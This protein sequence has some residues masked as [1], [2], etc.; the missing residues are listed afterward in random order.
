MSNLLRYSHSFNNVFWIKD[1]GLIVNEDVLLSPNSTMKAD[2]VIKTGTGSYFTQ[3]LENNLLE[4]TTYTLSLYIWATPTNSPT[5]KLFYDLNDGS[6]RVQTNDIGNYHAT[7][8]WRR[9]TF[10]FTTPATITSVDHRAGFQ[11][12][13]SAH[14]TNEYFF[15]GIQLVEGSEPVD[16][17]EEIEKLNIGYIPGD[18]IFTIHPDPY[19]EFA[20]PIINGSDQLYIKDYNLIK[21]PNFFNYEY[22]NFNHI[23]L[24]EIDVS[25]SPDDLT[26][27][28]FDIDLLEAKTSVANYIYQ[29]INSYVFRPNSTY[30]FSYYIRRISGG[31]GSS[32]IRLWSSGSGQIADSYKTVR[33]YWEL[34]SWTFT[35]PE[36]FTGDQLECGI[37]VT[38]S[39]DNMLIEIAD[40]QLIESDQRQEFIRILP[41][42]ENLV[43]KPNSIFCDEVQ[44]FN[45]GPL[46]YVT[47]TVNG[48]IR[49]E[50]NGISW[51][52]AIGQITPERPYPPVYNLSG[53][54][55][56]I[57]FFATQDPFGGWN[58]SVLTTKN[59]QTTRGLTYTIDKKLFPNFPYTLS[60]Y[61][62]NLDTKNASFRFSISSRSGASPS[63]I[64]HDFANAQV[65]FGE[66][67]EPIVFGETLDPP[68][69]TPNTFTDYIKNEVPVRRFDVA[70]D[71]TTDLA[72]IYNEL[73]PG[74]FV[75]DK[76]YQITCWSRSWETDPDVE[77]PRVY[78]GAIYRKT[79]GEIVIRTNPD[80]AVPLR[81]DW[82]ITTN[83]NIRF[84]SDIDLTYKPRIGIFA[85]GKI[86]LADLIFKYDD[87]I[88]TEYFSLPVEGDWS[89]HSLT[90]Y[91]SSSFFNTGIVKW[92]PWRSDPLV[93]EDRY[94]EILISVV[95]PSDPEEQVTIGV[96][97]LQLVEGIMP[98]PYEITDLKYVIGFD[99]IENRIDLK[100]NIPT[101][102][103]PS[104]KITLNPATIENDKF[105]PDT[106]IG[107]NMAKYDHEPIFLNLMDMATRWGVRRRGIF[108]RAQNYGPPN[109]GYSI[110]TQNRFIVSVNNSWD[111]RWVVLDLDDYGN[112]TK[113]PTYEDLLSMGYTGPENPEVNI[114]GLIGRSTPLSWF[115]F[116]YRPP[117]HSSGIYVLKWTGD[118]DIDIQ[119]KNNLSPGPYS[120]EIIH[121]E[122]G[123]LEIKYDCSLQYQG[124]NRDNHVRTGF[125]FRIH[126]INP[127]DYPKNFV[128]CEKRYEQLIEN[129]DLYYPF[130]LDQLRPATTCRTMHFADTNNDP[131]W[132]WVPER[133]TKFWTKQ[134]DMANA[135]FRHWWCCIPSLADDNYVRQLAIL[136]RDYLDPRLKIYLEYTN[137]YW[138]GNMFG[139]RVVNAMSE[140]YNYIDDFEGA[141]NPFWEGSQKA[142]AYRSQE[143]F[144]IWDEIFN[145][146]RGDLQPVR[147]YEHPLK[148]ERRIVRTMGGLRSNIANV[149]NV[150]KYGQEKSY[151]YSKPWEL[152]ASNNYYANSL[153]KE[154]RRPINIQAVAKYVQDELN[155]IYLNPNSPQEQALNFTFDLSPNELEQVNYG[156]YEGGPHVIG[157][158]GVG[159]MDADF[160]NFL[161][162]I[163]GFNLD[164]EISYTQLK[165]QFDWWNRIT[166]GR[167]DAV[168]CFFE[169]ANLQTSFM[170]FGMSRHLASRPISQHLYSPKTRAY[171]EQANLND[172]PTVLVKNIAKSYNIYLNGGIYYILL[173][174]N[175]QIQFAYD[176]LKTSHTTVIYFLQ[177]DIGNREVFFPNNVHFDVYNKRYIDAD[178][179]YVTRAEFKS[180]NDIIYCKMTPIVG[181]LTNSVPYWNYPDQVFYYDINKQYF[182][183]KNNL[184]SSQRTTRKWSITDTVNGENYSG[185][186]LGPNDRVYGIPYNHNQFIEIDYTQYRVYVKS[187][188]GYS[189]PLNSQLYFGGCLGQ[190]SSIYC[191]PYNASNIIKLDISS[192]T[193]IVQ[194]ID[195]QGIDLS[196]TEKFRGCI[197]TA[198][199]NKI[200]FIPFNY[201][202]V[203]IYDVFQNELISTDFGLDLS[204][205]SKW[206]GAC[207]GADNKIYCIPYNMDKIL[208]IDYHNLT[209]EFLT[210]DLNLTGNKKWAGSVFNP[211]NGKIY[212]T[213]FDSTDILIIDTINHSAVRTRLNL[214]ED[215][216]L[217]SEKWI[218]G[219]LGPDNRIYF[220]FYEHDKYLEINCNTEIA[221]ITTAS[222]QGWYTGDTFNQKHIGGVLAPN[223]SAYLVSYKAGEVKEFEFIP[224][225]ISKSL[226]LHSRFNKSF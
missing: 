93:I 69:Y 210:F 157:Q 198:S 166:E 190:D 128:F 180:F 97:G 33:D 170:T 129:G 201:N 41:F 51:G 133:H 86:D 127:L 118:C 116:E 62:K 43:L 65:M 21:F 131:E 28:I 120:G 216:L 20:Y 122:P 48:M 188:F 182:F 1:T 171:Y 7:G 50:G 107:L 90:F 177:D 70:H 17:V 163:W 18:T 119:N 176:P 38:A 155:Q 203:L 109:Y 78:M 141:I 72:F 136:T 151:D 3:I 108:D 81:K 175:I 135:S 146:P 55:D 11:L 37:N 75:V 160:W 164:S 208:V 23:T 34:N 61:A 137:E 165:E 39:S 80:T 12:N 192:H 36:N 54:D 25:H 83:N 77:I 162:L 82:F 144:N 64:D 140:Y 49:I 105:I 24:E 92:E 156:A 225:S 58:A 121:S 57:R 209:A 27:S 181:T 102:Q 67:N 32:R 172:F 139:S 138:N 132:E 219:I 214:I 200:V 8:E 124:G 2:G 193:P 117:Y 223:G 145:G 111:E 100:S 106:R 66:L 226:C 221:S 76:T 202:K 194:E 183:E 53:S 84:P 148:R 179:K 4:N 88:L 211:V 126:R 112:L 153:H 30:T 96:T 220:L 74:S 125:Y 215:D 26:E 5:I 42:L 35:L 103:I 16:Y 205:T 204:G 68:Q 91:P 52:N 168:Y 9:R 29:V 22:W 110:D 95:A 149:R 178:P 114:Y 150:W 19:I 186:V 134:M 15:Y 14:P 63:N 161:K 217:S 56:S 87:T 115:Y 159:G 46:P 73:E 79:D 189:L 85:T 187:D 143:I 195:L 158:A 101:I 222:F 199:D 59:R 142:F 130:Y 89:R 98:L 218:G 71:V 147:L 212:C 47:G 167:P 191:A 99:H 44:E 213:P 152:Y 184:I 45:K 94:P 173:T 31:T 104:G 6:G 154:Q 185:A 196:S 10:T 207:E 224:Q 113:I 197:S 174:S 206:Y 169:S 40:A 13:R 60:L 123:R